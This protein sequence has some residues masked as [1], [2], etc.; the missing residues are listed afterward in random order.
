MNLL[1]RLATHDDIPHLRELIHASVSV[2]SESHY[3]SRQIASALADIFGVDTQLIRDKTYFVAE[4]AGQIVGAG[5]W[6]ERLSLFG[7]DQTKSAEPDRL[8]DPATEPARIRAFYVHP[9]WA[10]RGIGGKI[11][12][13]CETE[14]RAAGFKSL[15]LVSTLPGEPLY[16]AKGYTKG[17]EIKL[18]TNDGEA[19]PCFRMTKSL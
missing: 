5:G 16:L 9:D 10:R 17:E 13:A 2:L 4:V 14:A 1:I 7:S 12:M 3:S 6:S 19:L 18:T 15:E 11:L 8:L